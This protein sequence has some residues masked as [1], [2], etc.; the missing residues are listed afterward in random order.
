MSNEITRTCD[1]RHVVHAVSTQLARE[2]YPAWHGWRADRRRQTRAEAGE[3]NGGGMSAVCGEPPE[4][5][6]LLGRAL[7]ALVVEP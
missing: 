2:G 1:L 4:V 5:D 3:V 6:R 7:G